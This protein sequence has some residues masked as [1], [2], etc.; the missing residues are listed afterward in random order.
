MTLAEQ[1]AEVESAISA[2]LSGGQ[3][4]QTRTGRVRMADLKTLRAQ[5]AAIQ[6]Q[7]AAESGNSGLVSMVFD[8]SE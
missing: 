8:G 1:L 7:I 5:Q 6:Q 4:V 3:E 2:I